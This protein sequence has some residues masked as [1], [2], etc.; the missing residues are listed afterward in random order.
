[1]SYYL[2]E[3]CGLT[4]APVR[5]PDHRDLGRFSLIPHLLLSLII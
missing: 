3:T 2:R 1:M 5:V 4:V